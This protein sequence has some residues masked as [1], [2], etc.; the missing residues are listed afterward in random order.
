[1]INIRLFLAL[2]FTLPL[3]AEEYVTCWLWGQLGNQLFEISTTLAYAWDNGYTPVFVEL[4]RQDRNVPLNRKTIFHRLQHLP[5]EDVKFD[6]ITID[7]DTKFPLKPRPNVKITGF[8]TKLKAFD[9]YRDRLIALFQPHPDLETH[10]EDN[11]SHLYNDPCSVGIQIRCEIRQVYP[12]S[13]FD[14]FKKAIDSFPEEAL[15]IVSASRIGWVKHH[16]EK[17]GLLKGRRHIYL[18]GNDHIT[19]FFILSRCKHLISSAST[20]GFWAGYF[21]QNPDRRIIAPSLWYR[22]SNPLS[23]IGFP[24]KTGD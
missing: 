8:A 11:F 9:H 3:A 20:F 12:F 21:N 7:M 4:D 22:R 14:Y 18:E 16:F 6:N 24:G 13:G 1:M 5:P 23:K 17:L 15:F 19:D 10:L 2:L